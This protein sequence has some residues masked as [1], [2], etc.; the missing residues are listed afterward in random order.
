M[1]TN[2][3]M[4]FMMWVGPTFD[5]LLEMSK[6]MP[7]M[8]KSGVYLLFLENK[9][10]YV[11]QSKCPAARIGQHVQ[12][13]RKFDSAAAIECPTE[14]LSDLESHYIVK[15]IPEGNR[16]LSSN[17]VYA[18]LHALAKLHNLSYH[19]AVT[20]LTNRGASFCNGYAL[21]YDLWSVVSHEEDRY[22]RFT[23]ASLGKA[24]YGFEA[25]AEVFR[26]LRKLNPTAEVPV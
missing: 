16:A 13:G 8:I 14:L 18:P 17:A 6:G 1:K 22:S 25:G 26:F 23:E 7:L 19:E 11:G 3:N 5:D 12:N 24:E 20:L 21:T 9:I 2:N 10:V 15:Y 4:K